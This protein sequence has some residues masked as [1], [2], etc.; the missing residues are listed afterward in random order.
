[1]RSIEASHVAKKM[2]TNWYS[3]HDSLKSTPAIGAAC[4]NGIKTASFL[5]EGIK[6]ILDVTVPLAL[7]QL[8]GG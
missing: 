8:G 3:S 1:M 7:R 5:A 4:F 2:T 6:V